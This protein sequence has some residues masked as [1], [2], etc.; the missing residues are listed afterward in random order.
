MANPS[1]KWRT[2][3]TSLSEDIFYA[4]VSPQPLLNPRWV[5]VN[6]ALVS[7]LDSLIDFD[8]QD[9][10]R[11]FSGGHPLHDWQ[12]LAQVYS[13][14]QFGQWAGQL[15]D[16][17]GLYLG[18]SGGYEWHL[19]GAGHTP[20]SRFGDG[21]S[22]LRSAIREY[23]GSEYI[24]ALGIPTTRALAVV[25]SDTPVQRETTETG[26]TLMRLAKSHLRIG[27]F[28]HFYHRHSHQHL[29]EIAEFAI[30]QLDPD[31]S[32]ASDRME[33]AFTRY[34]ERSAKLVAGWM[35]VG[36]VHGVMNTDNT[37][38]SGET[39]DFGP[40]GFV[41]AYRQDY[42]INHTD[43]TGRYAFGQQPRVMHW[44]LA[45]LAETLTPFVDVETLGQILNDFPSQYH[46][47]FR[48]EM[49]RRLA[50]EPENEQLPRLIEAIHRLWGNAGMH[51]PEVFVHLLDDSFVGLSETSGVIQ[52]LDELRR[53]WSK[54]TSSS[55]LNLARSQSPSWMLSHWLLD[56]VIQHAERGDYEPIRSLRQSMSDGLMN[57]SEMAAALGGS[58]P[59]TNSSYHLSCSS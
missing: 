45:C 29:R 33:I 42:V 41:M 50:I 35:A 17:R 18:V 38:L 43:Q 3:Y 5:D 53:L 25:A 26:A 6:Q 39:L 1:P 19:K 21:R 47:A 36:F 4:R 40:Y 9:A 57:P 51:Y 13:G 8:Q 11:A 49:A 54:E 20:Y 31:L 10:L 44:N 24:H 27:H 12:P 58:P 30:E 56:R 46:Q 16:G 15:G 37:A 23:L 2:P 59:D 7:E 48:S 32:G 28:E 22:V 52:S 55:L 34:V 14:H